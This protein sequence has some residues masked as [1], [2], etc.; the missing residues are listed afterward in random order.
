MRRTARSKKPKNGKRRKRIKT[1]KI[2]TKRKTR[3]KNNKKIAPT[4]YRENVRTAKQMKTDKALKKK[5][6]Y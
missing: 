6:V 4:T 3:R 1:T 5:P 2:T